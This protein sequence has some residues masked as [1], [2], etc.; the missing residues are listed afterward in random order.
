MSVS[1][2][3]TIGHYEIL[4]PIGKGGM[5]EVFRAR[6]TELGREVAIKVLP[7]AFA[8]DV[9]RLAR[10]EREAR[11]LASLNH[12]HVATLHGL[13]RAGETRFLVMELVAG[14]TL[15]ETLS[16]GRM[17]LPAA[18]SIFRQIAEALAAAHDRGVV[19]RDLKPANV[20]VTP[21]GNVKVLDFGL[22]KAFSTEL[23]TTV[24]ASQSPTQGVDP[25]EAGVVLGTA[26]YMSPEQARGKPVDRRA[27]V[28]SFGCVL[29]EALTGR[30]PFREETASETIAAVLNRGPDWSRLPPSTPTRIRELLRRTLE[31]DPSRRLRDMGDIGLEIAEAIETREPTPVPVHRS[32]WGWI[33]GVLG[34]AVGVFFA[35][36]SFWPFGPPAIEIPRRFAIEAS[37]GATLAAQPGIQQGAN[38]SLS[39]LGTH[40]AYSARDADGGLSIY[41]RPLDRLET[42]RL[43][44]TE[45]GFSPFFSPD[46]RWI[47]FFTDY[48][49]KKVSLDG[50]APL[51]LCD[52]PPVT[53]GA[54]WAP[55]DT[56]VFSPTFTGGFWRVSA[57]GGKTVEIAAP[58]SK[59]NQFGFLWPQVL[60]GGTAVLFTNWTGSSFDAA[61]IAVLPLP[62]GQPR[63]LVNSGSYAR[64]L[65]SGHLVFARAGA[66]L[67][68]P[69]DVNRLEV[70]GGAV[71]VLD[72]VLTSAS[73]GAASFDVSEDGTLAYIPASKWTNRSLVWMDRDGNTT[74]VSA[75]KREF[76]NPR[77]SPDGR[78]LAVEIANDIWIYDFE[79]DNVRRLTFEGI[80]QNPV[81]S[82]D[83]TRIAYAMA[84]KN[85][86]VL[87]L[88][89]SDGSGAATRLTGKT[90]VQFPS[91]WSPD[92]RVLAYADTTGP[93]DDWDTLVLPVANGGEP[94]PLIDGPF[95]QV[96]AMFSPDGRWL[97][98]VSD[99]SRRFEVYVRPYPSPGAKWQISTQGGAEPLWAPTGKE[100]YYRH[101]NELL[102]VPFADERPG[103][104]RLLFKTLLFS[105][106]DPQ[107]GFTSYGTPD[108]RRFIA[109]GPNDPAEA[110]RRILVTLDWTDELKR[111]LSR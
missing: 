84:K 33:V 66:L 42:Q 43:S 49:L 71:P 26:R 21:E 69:F 34:L 11:L 107:P 78:Q 72:G 79:R 92:G 91:S 105:E 93:L 54:S 52:V 89:M 35:S 15:A 67:A 13:E 102:V 9:D 106:P 81:W 87:Y 85:K 27:D 39:P 56:I 77:L 86:N 63:T 111:T 88:R 22:A 73:T 82:P 3:A 25:T 37:S 44:G 64:Y 45:G 30:H 2:G 100:I 57:G 31:K 94:T 41:L 59:K 60:P 40:L 10:F 29:Y 55:D 5:G 62:S 8:Q 7:E 19:H 51:T 47:G 99:E 74:P 17:S 76:Y 97:A 83:G 38:V 14:E 58:D 95:N 6:D 70:T 75:T 110:P 90:T 23:S 4:S 36:R 24:D 16:R 46:G 53:R 1:S 48:A 101:S 65:P 108:G 18:L 12:P 96:Q 61:E 20:K 104:P 50:G 80:N 98:Y 103:R 68:M 109:V 32:V 28:W